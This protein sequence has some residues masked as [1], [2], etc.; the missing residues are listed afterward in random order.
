MHSSSLETLKFFA[1]WRRGDIRRLNTR[2][3]GTVRADETPTNIV[4]RNPNFSFVFSFLCYLLPPRESSSHFEIGEFVA[5][6]LAAISLIGKSA[7][8]TM[9]K[10]PQKMSLRKRR[11]V[12]S[13]AKEIMGKFEL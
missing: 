3:E 8:R 10:T 1:R 7:I 11:S 9:E 4:L 5:V 6:A 13:A 12:I 2:K